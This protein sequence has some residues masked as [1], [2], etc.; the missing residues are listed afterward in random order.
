VNAWGYSPTALR[1]QAYTK[2]CAFYPF[3]AYLPNQKESLLAER[4]D[5]KFI[6]LERLQPLRITLSSRDGPTIDLTPFVPPRHSKRPTQPV[7]R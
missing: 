3:G 2:T 7:P 5:L 1:D 6:T 4:P